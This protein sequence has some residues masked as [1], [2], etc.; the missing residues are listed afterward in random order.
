M[1]KTTLAVCLFAALVLSGCTGGLSGTTDTGTSVPLEEVS[2]PNGTNE[3]GVT[4]P[5]ALVNAH[6]EFIADKNYEAT[7]EIRRDRGGNITRIRSVTESNLDRRRLRVRMERGDGTAPALFA[8]ETTV[9][10]KRDMGGISPL[11]IVK[12]RKEVGFND[13]SHRKWHRENT[14]SNDTASILPT[15]AI[16]LLRTVNYTETEA[17]RR[18]GRTFIKYRFRQ[19]NYTWFPVNAMNFT[20]TA[21][22]D[23]R[24]LIHRI[25][26]RYTLSKGN[27]TVRVRREYRVEVGGNVTVEQPDWLG[28]AYEQ[29]KSRS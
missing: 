25:T 15:S 1:R 20:S 14:W 2:F 21:V 27:K 12:P 11:Y 3:S 19:D 17:Y 16:E 7:F 23:E 9:V 18:D 26:H 4:D 22:I 24:G 10:R 6:D 8:N 28:E 13:T 5:Q 29:S